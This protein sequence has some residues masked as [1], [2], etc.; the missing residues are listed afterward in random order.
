MKARFVFACV[1]A[2]FALT[3][4]GATNAA[5]DANSSF[6]ASPGEVRPGDTIT[7]S[8]T[9]DHPD[10]AVPTPTESY[11]LHPTD[12]TGEQDESG[13]WHVSGTTT[14]KDNAQPGPGSVLFQCA[15]GDVAVAE[16]TIVGDEEPGEYYAA[17]G[18]D[19]DEIKAGQEVRV[20]ASCQTSEFVSSKIVS[21]V[22]TAP[23]IARG[24]GT[25]VTA[26]MFSMGRI[27]ADAKPGTY[28]ISFTCVDREVSGEFTVSGDS[29]KKT[30]E[31]AQVPVKP[32]GAADT[33]DLEESGGNP[34]LIGAGAAVLLVAGGV[35]VVAYRRRA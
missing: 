31:K 6:S 28:P 17:I 9:C 16:F 12:L 32:K 21:P 18:V 20:A 22:L 33:G 10:F 2:G 5:A 35:G 1:A 7:L 11:T 34:V 27:A 24:N 14:V 15:P 8:G 13:V 25:D 26:P 23:D 4:F 30:P 3:T 19:D 29:Q